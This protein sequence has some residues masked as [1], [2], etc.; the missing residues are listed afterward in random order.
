[1]NAN[2]KGFTLVELLIAGVMAALLVGGM[3][4]M[5]GGLARD[6]ARLQARGDV[7]QSQ[8]M[9][10][11]MRWDLANATKMWSESNA[12]TIEGYGGIDRGAMVGTNRAARV[13]YRVR[14][15]GSRSALVREQRFLDDPI[16]V[17]TW[18]EVIANGATRL[19]VTSGA[20]PE[21]AGDTAEEGDAMAPATSPALRSTTAGSAPALVRVR[22]EFTDHV[23]DQELRIR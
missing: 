18:T 15:D 7:G 2:R 10:E 19:T 3:A 8:E 12:V 13:V 6:R 21:P 14:S 17:Q 5:L 9:L 11:L 16:R 4:L 20:T 1:M 23:I 22:I